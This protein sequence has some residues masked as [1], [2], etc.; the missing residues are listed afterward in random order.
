MAHEIIVEKPR[1]RY[2]RIRNYRSCQ[3]TE[4]TPREGLSALIGK[5]SSG[6]TNLLNAVLL[7]KR[8]GEAQLHGHQP[9]ERDL[10]P[11]FITTH[12]SLPNGALVKYR[13][14][15]FCSTDESNRDDVRR[16]DEHWL[17]AESKSRSSWQALPPQLV[18]LM[19]HS[20]RDRIAHG[21]WERFDNL[22]RRYLIRHLKITPKVIL[23]IDKVKTYFGSMK[24]YSA[25]QFTNPSSCPIHF[26][27]DGEGKLQYP[28]KHR[29]PHDRLA[30]DIFRL[31]KTNPIAYERF[32]STIGKEGIGLVDS[33]QFPQQSLPSS[34]L[35]VRT[36]AKVVKKKSQKRIVIPQFRIH[37]TTLSTNQLSEGTLKALGLT[38][39]LMTDDSPLLLLEE[40]EVCVHHGLLKSIM[41]II[42]TYSTRKQIIITTHSDYLLNQLDPE[43]V[44]IVRHEKRKGTIAK[45]VPDSMSRNSYA[46]LKDYLAEEGGLGNFW[47]HGALGND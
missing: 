32:M 11:I 25:S 5:N 26:E 30:Y 33:I 17:I 9:Y 13:A 46:A 40:P 2:F 31:G 16:V 22:E 3:Y 41:E 12:V 43:A 14:R 44:F 20:I 35:E 19:T 4:L 23:D 8:I 28:H 15:V 18:H 47:K 10:T 21:D 37:G 27:I 6:K 7:L 42:K 36:G 29:S 34:S 38:F 1:L 39:Y 24:Y 45:S